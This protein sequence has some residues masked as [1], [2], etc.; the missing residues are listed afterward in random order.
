MQQQFRHLGIFLR[1][2]HVHIMYTNHWA[3]ECA[4]VQCSCFV[5]DPPFTRNVSHGAVEN[6][7]QTIRIPI[8]LPCFSHP[9]DFDDDGDEEMDKDSDVEAVKEVG[10]PALDCSN[11]HTDTLQKKGRL[12]YVY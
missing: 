1:H 7:Y 3:P 6:K 8:L 12:P 11:I 9:E 2:A 10:K 5:T 4:G